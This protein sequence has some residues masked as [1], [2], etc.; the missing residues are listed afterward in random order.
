[1]K[2]EASNLGLEIL[3]HL[4]NGKKLARCER[5][6]A[7]DVDLENI[8]RQEKFNFVFFRVTK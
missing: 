4:V 6:F 1:M 3:H 2:W 7:P 5:V 8:L